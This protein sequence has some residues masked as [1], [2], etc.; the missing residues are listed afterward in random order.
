MYEE[1]LQAL[2]AWAKDQLHGVILPWWCSDYIQDHE[3]GG[4]YGVVTIDMQRNNSEPRG[5]TLPTEG[6][7]DRFT[8]TVRNI[9][10]KN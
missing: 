7:A 1:R 2:S 4:Y 3:H 10:M 5:L 6:S 9:R 8:W